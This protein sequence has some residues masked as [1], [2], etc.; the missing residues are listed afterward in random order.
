[1]LKTKTK[2]G[3]RQHH[4]RS[5]ILGP[6]SAMERRDKKTGRIIRSLS[7]NVC[8]TGITYN[9]WKE[10]NGFSYDEVAQIGLAIKTI[11][12]KKNI[13]IL[14]EHRRHRVI[15]STDSG[16]AIVWEDVDERAG[17][18][19]IKFK[20]DDI[21]D[22]PSTFDLWVKVR[23]NI[24]KQGSIGFFII[25][26]DIIETENSILRVMKE[27]ELEELS[28]CLFGANPHTLTE[29][30]SL[31]QCS[32]FIEPEGDDHSEADDGGLDGAAPDDTSEP[33]DNHSENEAREKRDRM[34][35]RL[36][37]LAEA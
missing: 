25:K 14:H 8:A 2:N 16:T 27:I 35:A 34:R 5:V 28:M 11:S 7:G 20:I 22:S 3:E 18:T 1:M 29:A 9:I 23:D 30:R 12:E 24:V 36:R 4:R 33:E 26:E 21:G 6:D 13:A 15:A 17:N 32:C 37:L 10:R 31:Y 19:G